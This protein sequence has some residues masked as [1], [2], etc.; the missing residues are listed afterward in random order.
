MAKMCS[1]S[2]LERQFATSYLFHA[3]TRICVKC[4]SPSPPEFRPSRETATFRCWLV[5][6]GPKGPHRTESNQI[7]GLQRFCRLSRSGKEKTHKHKQICGIVPGLGGC[8]KQLFMC[9]CFFFSFLMGEK[10]HINRIPP[11][12]PGQSREH[13]VYV[14]FSLCVF[15]CF[16]PSRSGGDC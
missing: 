16:A 3:P 9:L 15:F 12:I 10:K 4:P 5:M 1:V 2:R 8:A 6:W 13:F 11:K 14:F 7:A